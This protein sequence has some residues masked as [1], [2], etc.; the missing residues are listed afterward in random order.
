MF[1]RLPGFLFALSA[2]FASAQSSDSLLSKDLD[3][4]VVTATRNER[5]MGALPMPVTLIPKANIRTMGSLRLTDVLTEQTGLVV[6]PQVNGQGNGIQLQGFNPDYT[7]IMIDG[8]PFV[9]RFTGSLELSRI[10]V[11]NIKKIEIV[12]GPSSSLYGSEALA[13]VIN[14]ITERPS[15]KKLGFYSRY[16]SNNTL[17]VNADASVANDKCGF[18]VFANR[19]STDGYDLSPNSKGQTVSPFSSYTYTSKFNYKITP[20]TEL[21]ISGRLFAQTQD[22]WFEV[23]ENGEN[24]MTSGPSQ[25]RDWNLN[26]VLTHRFTNNVKSTM[27]LY[28]TRYNTETNLNL[29]PANTPYYHDTFNQFFIRPEFNSEIYFNAKHI[30]TV[31]AGF[32]KESVATTRYNDSKRRYQQTEYVFMQHEWQPT[33]NF[34]VIGGLRFDKNSIYGSQLSPKL[35]M[36]WVINSKITLK[37]SVGVGFKAPDFRQLYYNFTNM[38][39]GGYSVLGSE[40]V[41]EIL[42]TLEAQGQ[43]GSYTLDP[44]EIGKLK[45]ERSR[46]IN[47]GGTWKISNLLSLDFN[48]FRNKVN[49]LIDSRIVA[50]TMGAQNIYSYKNINRAFTQGVELNTSY[51]IDEKWN[52]SLGY[53]LLYAKDIKVVDN[54]KKGN[55]FG[56]D[57]ETLATYRLKCWEYFGLYNRSRNTGNAKIFY[58][59]RKLGW[60]G[61][62]RVIYRG[63]YGAGDMMGNLQGE[64]IPSS[65]RNSNSIQDVYDNFVKG[66]ALINFSIGKTIKNF[67]LQGGVDN[68]FNYTE[69]VF[70]PNLPGRLAYV[71]LAYTWQKK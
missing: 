39:A 12:K 48:V 58:E 44:N 65:D 49:N 3:A 23:K 68:I 17:D 67:R 6:V 19:Y 7:L 63:R 22:N 71:S 24:V 14:I 60:F 38:A 37:G 8:E 15:G 66:Y 18:Y 61:S 52:L 53:Q 33:E 69:P 25:V 21:L 5:Q 70:I 51:R 11:G 9:G 36:R 56:R 62:L 35:S 50:V 45:A 59:D 41:R 54:I 43:I 10:A 34:N 57:P 26:P 4:V 42:A 20:K 1:K 46:S 47:I 13:G 64:S 40:V 32:I 16:G 28:A 27:R 29:Q 2:H 31:G 30:S 55:V